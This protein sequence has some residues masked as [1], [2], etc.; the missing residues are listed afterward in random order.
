MLE[1]AGGEMTPMNQEVRNDK[2]KYSRKIGKKK[3]CKAAFCSFPMRNP[4]TDFNFSAEKTLTSASTVP[5]HGG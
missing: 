2:D 1:E 3:T 4:L 5:E